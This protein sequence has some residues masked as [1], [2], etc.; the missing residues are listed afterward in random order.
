M[1]MAIKAIRKAK[2]LEKGLKTLAA[3]IAPPR[4]FD[5]QAL[6]LNFQI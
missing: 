5:N 3:E 1:I 6:A 4:V 2:S